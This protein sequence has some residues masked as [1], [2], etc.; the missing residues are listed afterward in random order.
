MKKI[1]TFLTIFILFSFAYSEGYV[2]SKL[3]EQDELLNSLELE[4]N[5]VRSTIN[6]LSKANK[7]LTTYT[8]S[9][10]KTIEICNKK[11]EDLQKNIITMKNALNSNKED[12]ST[13]L[14]ILGDMQL[15]LDN[16]KAYVNGLEQKIKRTNVL[17]QVMIPT[18]SLPIIANGV[19]MCANG[20][21]TYGKVCLY[22]GI[23]LFISAEV[24]WNGGKFIFKLW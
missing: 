14:N 16:Y 5:N 23:A 20:N 6:E 13:I 9:L 7:N 17:V 24:V 3:D 2:N 18:L 4:M 10:E 1:Y 21:E 19:Y 15:E 22:G 11:I 8:I 12:T